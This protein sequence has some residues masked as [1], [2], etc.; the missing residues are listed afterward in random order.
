MQQSFLKGFLKSGLVALTL[1]AA[2]P[3]AAG[4]SF[5]VTITAQNG[6]ERRAISRF[7]RIYAASSAAAEVIQKG[8][9]NAAAIA[10][11]GRG[12]RAV[13]SQQGDGHSATVTQSGRGNRL[14]VFQFGQGTAV[15]VDQSGRR[16]ATLVFTG[17]W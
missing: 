2:A 17:G 8:E 16:G 1:V 10:Q 9:G 3:A 14:G 7:L 15:D 6:Q 13:V 12:N 11:T 4:G 5:G